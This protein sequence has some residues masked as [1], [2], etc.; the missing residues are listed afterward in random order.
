MKN[1]PVQ[2]EAIEESLKQGNGSDLRA[3]SHK[4][5]G[6]CLAFGAPAMAKTSEQIQR[7]SEEGNLAEIAPLVVTLK[8]QYEEVVEVLKRTTAS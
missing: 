3:Y 1:V 2:I 8:Q 7:L 4:T 6:S 5:K